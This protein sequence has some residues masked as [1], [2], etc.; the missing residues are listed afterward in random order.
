MRASPSS[1]RSP[2]TTTLPGARRPSHDP[3]AEAAVSAT[4]RPRTWATAT[5]WRT[6]CSSARALAG[7]HLTLACPEGHDPLPD[8]PRSAP[9]RSPRR[10][11]R[12]CAS[13]AIPPKPRSTRTSSSPTRGRRWVRRTEHATRVEVFTPY[14]VD[15]ALMSMADA[16]CDLHALPAGASR[17]RGHGRGHRLAGSVVFDEAE[18]RLHAQKALLTSCSA[19]PTAWGMG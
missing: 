8:G 16:G 9:R 7:M 11:A 5:T 10:P 12:V 4:C 2:T 6:R 15:E 17:R 19:S 1:T 3:G 14:R 13:S 18:N